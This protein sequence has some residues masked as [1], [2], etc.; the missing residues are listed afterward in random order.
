MS[1]LRHWAEVIEA[2]GSTQ[3]ESVGDVAASLHALSCSL[4]EWD[5]KTFGNVRGS[6]RKLKRELECLRS[7]PGRTGPSLREIEIKK[8]LLELYRREEMPIRCSRTHKG[9][10]LDV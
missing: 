7:V 1:W 9:V 5:R 10:S 6:I 2:W 4:G 3:G 8:E